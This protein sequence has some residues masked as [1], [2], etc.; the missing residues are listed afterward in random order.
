MSS[1]DAPSGRVTISQFAPGDYTVAVRFHDVSAVCKSSIRVTGENAS[2]ILQLSADGSLSTVDGAAVQTG[3]G[4]EQL[5]SKT[6]ADLPL[7]KRDFSQLLLLAA[8]TMT[9]TNG[10]A[11]FTQQFAVNGQRGPAAV[12]AMDGADSGLRFRIWISR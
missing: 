3:T 2:L 9:D 1:L 6:V 4:G 11:N 12:F 8:G 5:S 10:S 7:N